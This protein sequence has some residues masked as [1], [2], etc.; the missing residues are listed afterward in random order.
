MN[1]TLK[2][3]DERI[4]KVIGDEMN[5]PAVDIAGQPFTRPVAS[6]FSL[7]APEGEFWFVVLPHNFGDGETTITIE[8]DK[9]SK[10][11]SE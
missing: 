5:W 8:A 3:N 6:T 4:G 7:P 9:K 1:I 2:P 10:V 11:K